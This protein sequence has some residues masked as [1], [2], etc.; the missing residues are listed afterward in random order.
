MKKVKI[1]FM[2]LLSIIMSGCSL[3]FKGTWCKYSEIPTTLLILKENISETE[4][5]DLTSFIKSIDNLKSYDYIDDIEEAYPMITIYY[6]NKDNIENYESVLS[7]YNSVSKI[8]T[9][10]MNSVV[11]RLVIKNNT[12]T[13]GTKLNT[14][15]AY[16]TSG[17]Y[18]IEKNVLTLDDGTKFY[19]KDKF[20]CYSEECNDLLIKAK[21]NECQ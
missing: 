4:L 14:I 16:E 13:Y 9:S 1:L 21:G 12:F 11:E 5:N 6:L 8:K 15:Y 20:L 17:K 18:E 2:V 7:T 19:Y 10:K 3:N